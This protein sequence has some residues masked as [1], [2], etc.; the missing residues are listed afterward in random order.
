MD[1]TINILLLDADEQ[2]AEETK[3]ALKAD[4][5]AVNVSHA[6]EIADG[7]NYLNNRKPDLILL[8]SNMVSRKDFSS[9]EKVMTATAVPVILL[10]ELTGDELN[11]HEKMSGAVQSLPKN[12]SGLARLS[13]VIKGA[14]TISKNEA[15]VSGKI[16]EA[17]SQADSFRQVLD[18]IHSGVMVINISNEVCYANSKAKTILA[19]E[20]IRRFLP[21]YFRYREL[22]K[23]GK[24]ELILKGKFTVNISLSTVNWNDEPAN[25]FVFDRTKNETFDILSDEPLLALLNSVSENMLLLKEDV[26]VY[27]NRNSAKTL[28]LDIEEIISKPLRHFLEP[29]QVAEQVV[30]INSLFE[31][32]ETKATIHLSG[33][34]TQNSRFLK[35]PVHI[36]N[37]LYQLLSFAVVEDRPEQNIPKAT[38][39]EKEFTA[40]GILHLASHD[41]REPV[42]TILNYIQLASQNIQNKKY[43]EAVEFAEFAKSAAGR[44]DKLLSDLKF[45]I[46]LNEHRFTL[47]KVSVS[48]VL[49]DVL[50]RLKAAAET[51][52]AE[53]SFAGLPE[54]NADRGLLEKLL[55]CLIDNAIKFHRKEKKPVIDIGY[56]K[57]EGNIIFCV[58]DNGIGVSKKYYQKIFEPFEK[59]NRVD[60]Y[61]GNGLGLAISKKI[62][63][64]HG[65]E[66]WVESLPGSGSNFYFTLRGK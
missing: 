64:M 49:S 46:G 61:P 37:E 15:R 36:N 12:Q 5:F 63:E 32:K 25:L 2:S 35:R 43:D 14:I 42:R 65:G 17:R 18:S 47:G 34:A 38:G 59:L 6:S 9:L 57:F 26:I 40:G 24:T 41:L 29:A 44:M 8:D 53:I 54:I 16:N 1:T 3:S 50:K 51:A 30:T 22:D 21:E 52:Q 31:E 58:R 33:G 39:Q 7:R 48:S 23:K 27:A 66:I 20:S 62:V 4:G 13:R 11:Q 10:S 45:F 28:K 55:E 56:D 60:E 19:D